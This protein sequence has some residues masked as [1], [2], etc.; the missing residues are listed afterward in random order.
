MLPLIKEI[1]SVVPFVSQTLPWIFDPRSSAT[2]AQIACSDKRCQNM[3]PDQY[4]VCTNSSD[5]CEL[6]LSYGPGVPI[7]SSTTGYYVSDVVHLEILGAHGRTST[8][9]ATIMF[10]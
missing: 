2:S 8:A 5:S 10:G 3:V 6:N 1:T 7:Y 9:P 4:A